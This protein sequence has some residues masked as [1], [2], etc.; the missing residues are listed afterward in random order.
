MRYYAVRV[1]K[2]TRTARINKADSPREA[3]RIGFGVTPVRKDGPIY[4]HFECKDLGPKVSVIQSDRK[5]IAL[6]M[7]EVGW[8]KI[9]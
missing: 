6:L 2:E 1:R 3:L 8:E 7:D 9:K 5:R 4:G